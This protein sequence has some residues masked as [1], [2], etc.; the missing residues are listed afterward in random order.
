M[1]GF[2]P[3]SRVRFFYNAYSIITSYPQSLLC[4]VYVVPRRR[5]RFQT[6]SVRLSVQIVD[7]S[8]DRPA[9]KGFPRRRLVSIRRSHRHDTISELNA[10]I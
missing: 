4:C 7:P 1:R 9:E 10:G 8:D 6:S 2:Y 5:R 3:L